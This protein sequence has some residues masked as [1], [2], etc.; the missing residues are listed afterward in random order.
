MSG[1]LKVHD[2]EKWQ[3]YRSDRPA[4]PWIKVHRSALRAHKMY[5][6][7]DEERGQLLFIWLLASEC[8]GEIPNDSTLVQRVCGMTSEP[9]LNKLIDLGFL[10]LLTSGRQDDAN[11]TGST[12]A[13]D[14]EVAAQSR[15]EKKYIAHPQAN[16]HDFEHQ[17]E[18]LDKKPNKSDNTDSVE[19][20]TP[21][22]SITE[23]LFDQFWLLYPNR[24]GKK[25]AFRAWKNLSRKNQQ[26]ALADI[27]NGRFEG[28]DKRFIPHPTT[29]LHGERWNDELATQSE[30]DPYW[31]N[32]L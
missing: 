5:R 19:E 30:A 16:G 21:K 2:W 20:S 32:F 7:S 12:R 29:Y 11:V 28:S 14:A 18:Q 8:N 22:N 10:D 25:R 3:T 9:N 6:L 15:E 13:H 17:D 26:A 23:D 31:K 4:P 1:K 27:R 24:V